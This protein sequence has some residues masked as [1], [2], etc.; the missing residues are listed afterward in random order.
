MALTSVFLGLRVYAEEG[1]P[2][3]TP[4]EN[5]IVMVRAVPES[6]GRLRSVA[7]IMSVTEQGGGEPVVRPAH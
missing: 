7:D 4:V 2:S 6:S 1:S 5:P 3:T